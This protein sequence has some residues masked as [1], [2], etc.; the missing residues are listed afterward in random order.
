MGDTLDILILAG[1][2]ANGRRRG[3]Q[4]STFL[5]GV[6]APPGA[7]LTVGGSA[8]GGM[9]LFYPLVKVS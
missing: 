7:A 8:A 5:V 2:F 9:P 4:L 6:K 3:G 1:Y